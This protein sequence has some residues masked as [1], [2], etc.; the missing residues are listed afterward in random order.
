[1]DIFVCEMCDVDLHFIIRL[2]FLLIKPSNLFFDLMKRTNKFYLKKMW[3]FSFRN[4]IIPF[5]T[6][7]DILIPHSNAIASSAKYLIREASNNLLKL[8]NWVIMKLRVQWLQ[9]LPSIF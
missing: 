2:A 6:F 5:D 7:Y 9:I 8:S 4:K 3:I 1:M